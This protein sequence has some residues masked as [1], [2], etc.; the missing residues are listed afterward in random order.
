VGNAQIQVAENPVAGSE[1]GNGVQTPKS[2]AIA[3]LVRCKGRL[4]DKRAG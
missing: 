3:S 2:R 1:A 4:N